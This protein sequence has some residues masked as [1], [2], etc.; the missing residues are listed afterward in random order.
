MTTLPTPPEKPGVLFTNFGGP[1]R[2]EELV[3]FLEALL[4]DV[5]PGPGWFK[6]FAGRT[7]APRRATRVRERYRGI[8]WSPVTADSLRQLDAVRTR[9]PAPPPMAAGMMF[10]AP[11]IQDAVRGLLDQGV[12][13]LVVL[14]LFPHWSFATSGASGDMVHHA[15][16]A[17]GRA[18]L[19]VHNARSFFDDPRYVEAVAATIRRTL[20]TLGGEGPV[21]LVFSAHGIPVSFVRR[22]D[23]Y[24]DHVRATV[25]AVA[26]ALDW[27]DPVHLGWQSRLGPVRWLGPNV[28]DLV[29]T[30]ARGGARRMLVVPVS[31]VG[32]HIE[33]LDELDRELA[34]HAHQAGVPHFAR[35]PA[36]GLEPAFLDGLAALVQEALGAFHRHRCARCLLPKPD[37]HFRQKQCPDCAFRFP[38]HMREAAAR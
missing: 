33:T 26:A 5:L 32:E 13:H 30:L 31:F 23:P 36:L 24:P 12:D 8:G 6:R 21:H 3:P 19:P 15:L 9:L 29:D 17:L 10:T 4:S 7:L 38:V 37:A 25:R 27:Q 11:S 2:D 14:G 20:P 35:A 34:E 22:G 18:D 1:T 28:T 16:T